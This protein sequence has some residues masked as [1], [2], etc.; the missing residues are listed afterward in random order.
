MRK[1][2]WLFSIAVTSSLLA[3]PGRGP[4][5]G[6][7]AA[8][9]GAQYRVDAGRTGSTTEVGPRWLDTVVWQRP[10]QG[11]VRGLVHDRGVLYAGAFGK[12]HA[13]HPGTGADFWTFAVPNVQFSAVAVDGDAVYVAGGNVFYALD[14]ASGTPLWSLDAGASIDQSSP[15]I[16]HGTAY[17]GSTAGTVHAIDL[18]SHQELWRRS[19]GSPVRTALVASRGLLIAVTDGGLRALRTKNGEERWSRPGRWGAAAAD[20]QFVYAG[21]DAGAFHALELNTGAVEWTY[22][23]P[24]HASVA[25]SR[26]AVSR[27]VLT[28]GNASGWLYTVDA[29]TG[30]RRLMTEQIG[31]LPLTE[32]VVSGNGRIYFG[33]GNDPVAPMQPVSIYVVDLETGLES[34]RTIYGHVTGGVAVADEVMFVHDSNNTLSAFT[35]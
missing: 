22:A 35:N 8:S 1:L 26:P 11:P 10:L 17:V 34:Q 13:V 6:I 16:V 31:S 5:I 20:D 3:A 33:T 25:W 18:A 19:I 4:A 14:R 7:R 2:V 24:D 28:V 21:V 12:V 23:D 9:A 32:P 27:K 15:V 29:Q 30:A